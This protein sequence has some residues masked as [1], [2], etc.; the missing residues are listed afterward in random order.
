MLL[1]FGKCSKIS[2]TFL[3]LF[4]NKML[5]ISPVTYKMSVR[6]AKSEN[7]DKTA[8]LEVSKQSDLCLQC[9]SRFLWQATTVRNFRIL[10]L[11]LE[12]LPTQS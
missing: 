5:V 6:K 8:S 4:S 1:A 10:D 7:T 9:L 2:N 3:F 12:V 11:F